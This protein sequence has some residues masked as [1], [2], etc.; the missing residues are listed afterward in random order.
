MSR[1][2][3]HSEEHEATGLAEFVAL[4]AFTMSL[5]YLIGQAYDG[6]LI[7]MAAGFVGLISLSVLLTAIVK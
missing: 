3:G 4:M 1:I 5:G 2:P 7:P 6:T